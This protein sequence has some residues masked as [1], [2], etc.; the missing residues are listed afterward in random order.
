M[1]VTDRLLD[2]CA[3]YVRRGS[4]SSTLPVEEPQEPRHPSSGVSTAH[5]MNAIHESLLRDHIARD[6]VW[7]LPCALSGVRRMAAVIYTAEQ[8]GIFAR[9]PA[10]RTCL[11]RELA[12]A[13]PITASEPVSQPA[14]I[15]TLEAALTVPQASAQPDPS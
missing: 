3:P 7:C 14:Y 2:R 1:G 6:T 4:P 5:I 9:V 11:Q 13:I 15:A 10:C 12:N 8:D